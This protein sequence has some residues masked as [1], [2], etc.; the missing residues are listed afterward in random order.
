[1]TFLTVLIV[2]ILVQWWGSAAPLHHDRWF[3]NWQRWLCK[4]TVLEQLPSGVLLALTLLGPLLVLWLV[5]ATVNNIYPWLQLV[6]AV[7]LLLYCL[8]RSKY[9][10]R[11]SAYNKALNNDDWSAAIDSYKKMREHCAA[12][13]QE[14]FD[15]DAEEWPRLH[16]AM[17]VATAYRG[18][19]RMFTV[20][21]WFVAFGPIGALLYR[22][23]SLLIEADTSSE[24]QSE[25]NNR[26]W[27]LARHW[28]WVLEWPVVRV[29]SLS[30][31]LTGNF[32]SCI[33]SFQDFLLDTELSSEGVLR[34][35]IYGALNLEED[36]DFEEDQ[37]AKILRACISLLSRTIILWICVLA[38]VTLW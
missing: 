29:L 12:D 9:T 35:S 27:Q 26:Y 7:P 30:F 18:F 8:G 37:V 36:K 16:H 5:L 4:Q 28:V 17:L 34:H 11:V 23:S 14:Q 38:V 21:F 20:L 32:V 24:E 13:G 15:S 3:Y 22:L 19:E 33:Q 31:A 10:A 25:D 6:V 2:F 1:M